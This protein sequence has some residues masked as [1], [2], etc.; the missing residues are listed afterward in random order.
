MVLFEFIKFYDKMQNKF[1]IARQMSIYIDIIG[2]Y[3]NKAMYR[4]FESINY[5]I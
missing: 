3:R 2:I 5:I 4:M 1:I